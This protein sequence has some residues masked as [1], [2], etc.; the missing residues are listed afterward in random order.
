NLAAQ[1]FQLAEA[2][3]FGLDPVAFRCEL[4]RQCGLVNIISDD[5][6]NDVLA[7][8]KVTDGLGVH[9]VVEATGN[10]VLVHPSL[11]MVR[12]MGEVILLGS[13]RGNANVDIYNLIHRK[14]VSL[15]GAHEALIPT[16]AGSEDEINQQS[17]TRQMLQHLQNK[18][19]IVDPLISRIISPGQMNEGYKA[20]LFQKDRV[21]GILVD[22]SQ[23]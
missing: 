13:P 2:K 11:E 5:A 3:V 21:V 23:V 19:L 18:Q 12:Q 16:M 10:P 9:I 20:L 14:G 8:K 4:A 1:L 6:Q 7:I 17:I 22:W 15:K